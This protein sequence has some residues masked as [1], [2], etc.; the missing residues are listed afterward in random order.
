MVLQINMASNKR[1]TK[2]RIIWMEMVVVWSNITTLL[3]N[4]FT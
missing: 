2:Q 1:F 4:N 3:E